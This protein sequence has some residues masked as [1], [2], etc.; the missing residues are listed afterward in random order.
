[1]IGEFHAVTQ[2]LI[3]VGHK[4]LQELVGRGDALGEYLRE[5]HLVHQYE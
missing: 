4:G 2:E 1:M 5:T 3:G